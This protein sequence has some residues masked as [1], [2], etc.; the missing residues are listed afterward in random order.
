MT[1]TAVCQ[2]VVVVHGPD[3]PLVSS[4]LAYVGLAV[5][6]TTAELAV[7]APIDWDLDDSFLDEGDSP[8][9][10]VRPLNPMRP[11][12]WKWIAEGGACSD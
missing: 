10:S 7:W 11:K 9:L 8:A 12:D 1:T 3:D 2:R 6:Y 4:T 5:V